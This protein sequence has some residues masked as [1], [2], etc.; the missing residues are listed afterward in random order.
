MET[1]G[2]EKQWGQHA[3]TDHQQQKTSSIKRPQY[4]NRNDETTQTAV[5]KRI[6]PSSLIAK[7]R[8]REKERNCGIHI[9]VARLIL[10]NIPHERIVWVMDEK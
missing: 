8:T 6:R 4:E 3:T 5:E 1:I 7:L 9:C 2:K 10:T